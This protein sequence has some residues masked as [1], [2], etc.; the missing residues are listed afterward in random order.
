MRDT[1]DGQPRLSLLGDF[2][3]SLGRCRVAVSSGAQRLLALLALR[4]RAVKRSVAAGTLW[5]DASQDHAF[6][7]LRAALCRLHDVDRGVIDATTHHVCLAPQTT[8]DVD[9]SR[10][11]ARHLLDPNY[12]PRGG[13]DLGASTIGALSAD[14]LP[15]WPDDWVQVEA[16]NWRQLRLRALDALAARLT[17]AQRFDEAATAALT[18]IAAEPLRET[19]R[20]GLIRVHLA[21]G[22]QSEAIR[23]FRRYECLLHNELGLK[24]T[25]RLAGL[26]QGLGRS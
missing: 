24:P 7:S 3:L 8:V 2:Y 15:D 4:D 25:P 18:A 5:P 20:A 13:D 14:L 21:E 19:S 6:A 1:G 22:N 12:R 16:E 17:T 23:E 11:V 9:E 10:A 26:M